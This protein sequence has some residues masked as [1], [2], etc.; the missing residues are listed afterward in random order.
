MK[1]TFFS[2][3]HPGQLRQAH[4]RCQ[5]HMWRIM[6]IAMSSQYSE[7]CMRAS[8][9][10]NAAFQQVHI[11]WAQTTS[12]LPSQSSRDRFYSQKVSNLVW[13]TF[14]ALQFLHRAFVIYS[15]LRQSLLLHP[16]NGPFQRDTATTNTNSTSSDKKNLP[17]WPC[18]TLASSLHLIAPEAS[19]KVW[20]G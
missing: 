16:L 20:L 1:M 4:L 14:T 8:S 2:I 11:K 7:K 5:Q 12:P 10:S 17:S 3:P 6:S 13:K 15:H 19:K 9:T 18:V